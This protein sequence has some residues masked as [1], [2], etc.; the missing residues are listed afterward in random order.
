MATCGHSFNILLSD[1]LRII[2]SQK[3]AIILSEK[4]YEVAS[5]GGYIEAKINSNI[6]Y[7]IDIEPNAT[8]WIKQIP[9]E[10]KTKSLVEKKYV[11]QI[12]ENTLSKERIGY[13]CNS[14]RE[15]HK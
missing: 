4:E 14:C 6:D 12:L 2:Q 7:A 9:Q 3:D 11:F 5:E 1:T 15:R 8:S 13:I 10:N